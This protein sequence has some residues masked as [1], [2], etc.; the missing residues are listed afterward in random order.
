[1]KGGE[2]AIRLDVGLRG[3]WPGASG[4]C[5]GAPGSACVFVWTGSRVLPLGAQQ[6]FNTKTSVQLTG[7]A[8]TAC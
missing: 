7:K 3:N 2:N 8:I 4:S 5:C 6:Y 1:M